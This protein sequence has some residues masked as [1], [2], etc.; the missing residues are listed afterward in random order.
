VRKPNRTALAMATSPCGR[1]GA[2]PAQNFWFACTGAPDGALKLTGPTPP[3][4]SAPLPSAMGR[5]QVVRQRILIPPFPGSNPGAPAIIILVRISTG[6]RGKRPYLQLVSEV[7]FGLRLIIFQISG[8]KRANL[9][10]GLS[11][12]FSNFRFA[13]GS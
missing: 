5:S 2:A 4:W 1:Q 10:P 11:S 12:E 7:I 3:V 8:T 6:F 9:R 13:S